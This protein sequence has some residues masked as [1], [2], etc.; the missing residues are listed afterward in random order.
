[1]SRYKKWMCI[2]DKA[3]KMAIKIEYPY[4][5]FFGYRGIQDLAHGRHFVKYA[6]ALWYKIFYIHNITRAN[7]RQT[8]WNE[9]K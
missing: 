6:T 2:D 3:M 1:M 5:N 4:L 8:G 7:M 9:P